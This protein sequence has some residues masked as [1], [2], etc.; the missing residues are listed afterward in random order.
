MMISKMSLKLGVS[1]KLIAK[2]VAIGLAGMLFLVFFIRVATFEH[3]YYNEMEGSEREVVETAVKEEEEEEPLVEEV[4]TV[5]EVVEYTVAA[6]RP[7]Y[8]S[9]E[10]LGIV[11]ARIISVGVKASGELGTPNNIFDVGWYEAS[12]KPGQGRTLVIDG[13]NG[14]PHVHGV[15]KDLPYLQNGDIIVIER[16]DGAI[17]RYRVVENIAVALADSDAYMAT[18][19]RTPETGRESVTL[20]S[21]TGEWSQQQGTYLSRQFTRAVL[22]EE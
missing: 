20:I 21:C 1:P 7:R 3:A 17:F 2:W 13:H 15:F 5:E 4:P 8:L 9:I 6:D 16:G 18:A 19:L 22:V 11:N 10:R 14:G 12:G